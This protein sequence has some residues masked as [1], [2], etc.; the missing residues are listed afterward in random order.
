MPWGTLRS[1][2]L[3]DLGFASANELAAAIH[4][5]DIEKVSA[6]LNGSIPD[7]DFMVALLRRYMATPPLYFVESNHQSVA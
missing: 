5:D 4:F 1:G 3:K 2:L 6:A 7:D